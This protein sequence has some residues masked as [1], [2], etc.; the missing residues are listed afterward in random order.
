[1]QP[2]PLLEEMTLSFTD[3]EVD[4]DAAKDIVIDFKAIG[5]KLMVEEYQFFIKD[6]IWKSRSGSSTESRSLLASIDQ[7]TARKIQAP[8]ICSHVHQSPQ[9]SIDSNTTLPDSTHNQTY[10]IKHPPLS[11]KPI[12]TPSKSPP[13]LPSLSLSPTTLSYPG[14]SLLLSVYF[15]SSPSPSPSSDLFSDLNVATVDSTSFVSLF[16]SSPPV[17]GPEFEVALA[18][19]GLD[20]DA[21]A[22]D[23]EELLP[24]VES[25][26]FPTEAFCSAVSSLGEM[27][28]EAETRRLNK[29][30]FLVCRTAAKVGAISPLFWI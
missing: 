13:H 30:I 20:I 16:L 6:P 22:D 10:R 18:F 15:G 3:E 21:E 19:W 25:L 2:L 11:L 23:D 9:N 7:P 24:D 29:D 12:I 8:E 28:R 14:N 26:R 1:M 17:L 27:L 4:K 5:I